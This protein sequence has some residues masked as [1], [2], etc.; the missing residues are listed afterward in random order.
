MEMGECKN[1]VHRK[2]I[3]DRSLKK[4]PNG[5]PGT[6]PRKGTAA[7]VQDVLSQEAYHFIHYFYNFLKRNNQETK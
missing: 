7:R 6:Y 5:N 4:D 3:L 2:P 1:P